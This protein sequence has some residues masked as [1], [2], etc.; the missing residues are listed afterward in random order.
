MWWT[1]YCAYYEKQISDVIPVEYG[2]IVASISSKSA[3]PGT[4][5]N[6]DEFT[7]TTADALEQI[8][9]AKEAKAFIEDQILLIHQF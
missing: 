1:S 6:I 7:L 9:G 4:R 8:G 2:E 3:G 5:Q